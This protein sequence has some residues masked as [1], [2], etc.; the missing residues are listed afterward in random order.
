MAVRVRTNARAGRSG[1]F[2]TPPI[3]LALLTVGC[4]LL[5]ATAPSAQAAGPRIAQ[6]QEVVAMFGRHPARSR[7]A[8]DAPVVASVGVRQPIT[9]QRTTLPVLGQSIDGVG[10]SWLR[11]RLPGRVLGG[12]TPPR[13]GWI[14]AAKTR[15][16]TTGWHIVVD[17]GARRVSVYKDGKR[18]RAFP[19]IV[20]K[21]STPTPRGEYFVEETVR[22]PTNKPGAPF[23]LALSA[24]S[25]VFQE[26]S[27]GPG[28]IA[29]HGL[30][31]VG[32]QLGTAVSFGCV[33]VANGDVTWLATRVA[34]GVPVTI[35]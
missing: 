30:A 33:R 15:L 22:M 34:A 5:P 6:Y 13:I 2:A 35:R 17:V 10:R 26:F 1:V 4:L 31:N 3:G 28:Q 9:D 7:P 27:G 18:I 11:V 32:G 20:G 8:I 23:A 14:L 16:E 29:I 21:P 19:A 25:S 24:R 12:T